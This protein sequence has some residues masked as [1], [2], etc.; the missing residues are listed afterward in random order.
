MLD[1]HWAEMTSMGEWQGK[2][3]KKNIKASVNFA[4]TH[5]DEP[6]T[7]LLTDESG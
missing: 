6:H 7:V 1:K 2:T 3:A 4:T 5:L